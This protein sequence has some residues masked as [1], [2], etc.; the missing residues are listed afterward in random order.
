M[1]RSRRSRREDPPGEPRARAGRAP[2]RTRLDP[3]RRGA[4]GRLGR[5]GAAGRARHAGP[6]RTAGLRAARHVR[7]AV[8]GDR[9]R[10]SGRSPAATRQ[11]ASR[12]RRRVRG[13][14]TPDAGDF[15][16]QR[17][18]VEAF[19]AAARGGDFEALVAV[20]D[21]DVVL[22]VGDGG[23]AGSVPRCTAPRRWPARRSPSPGPRRSPSRSGGRRGRRSWS[24]HRPGPPG[25]GVHRHRRTRHRDRRG[26]RPRADPRARPRGTARADRVT[27]S[28]RDD[29]HAGARRARMRCPKSSVITTRRSG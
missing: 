18:V 28:P 15:A 4:A 1:L 2:R 29:H 16:E 17:G 27:G 12:A 8:R 22:R 24:R 6:G 10:S 7:R 3:E 19:L 21:P 14:A 23:P 11:L 20:L 13:A 26:R 25:V 5:A 9:P